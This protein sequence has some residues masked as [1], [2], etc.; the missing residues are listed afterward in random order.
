MP[1]SDIR[2]IFEIRQ[3]DGQQARELAI[4]QAHVMREVLEWLARGRYS[5]GQDHAA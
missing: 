3:A 5:T 4:T 1:E 2:V